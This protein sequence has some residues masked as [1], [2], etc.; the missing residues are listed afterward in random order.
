MRRYLT[1]PMF[2]GGRQH[3]SVWL[4]GPEGVA[5][6]VVG[7]LGAVTREAASQGV[8]YLGGLCLEPGYVGLFGELLEKALD[9]VR[10]VPHRVVKLGI[11]ERR[12]DLVGEAEKAGFR[13]VYHALEMRY[14][15]TPATA[16]LRDR[17][18]SPCS[19]SG[20]S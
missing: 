5:E 17:G 2:E 3:I 20:R 19:F 12:G 18:E 6:R 7:C 1:G 11:P 10:R 14:A 4:P 13:A 15:G 16:H 8:V 9:L